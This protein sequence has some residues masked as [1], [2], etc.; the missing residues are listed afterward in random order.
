MCRFAL[1][2]RLSH[3]YWCIPVCIGVYVPVY[4][5]VCLCILLYTDV[6]LCIPYLCI[7]VFTIVYYCILL[8][9]IVCMPV[10]PGVY[11]CIMLYTCIYWCIPVYTCVYYHISVSC[12][13]HYK[14]QSHTF[15]FS[16]KL[17]PYANVCILVCRY[18]ERYQE[19]MVLN[20]PTTG[21]YGCLCMQYSYYTYMSVA[22][23]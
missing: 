21:L 8:Y 9:T 22:Y 15:Y 13:I 17:Q 16:Y 23:L 2:C 6:Y 7:L 19:N 3:I 5:N 18:T 12:V 14:L 4:T 20:H 1:F 11:L 10:Y